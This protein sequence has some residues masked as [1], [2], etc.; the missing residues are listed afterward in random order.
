M[1]QESDRES[2]EVVVHA[3]AV[4][5]LVHA[6]TNMSLRKVCI[7]EQKLRRSLTEA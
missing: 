6:F 3:C 7:Y 5:V 1:P 4:I 2:M